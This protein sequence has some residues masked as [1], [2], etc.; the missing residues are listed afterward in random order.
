MDGQVKSGWLLGGAQ[1]YPIKGFVP[2]FVD[3]DKYAGT[4]SKQRLYVRKHFE[5]YRH[6]TSGDGQ[7]WPTTGFTPEEIKTGLTL[8]VGC[9]YG[10]FVDVVSRNGGEIVGLDLSTHSIELAQDF[11]GM[12]PDVHLVQA[13]L[14]RPPF[15][16]G[17][18]DRLYSIG[19]LHHT[20]STR[21]AVLACL[22]LVKP[23]GALAFWVYHPD[24]KA[25]T[26]KVRPITAR[27]PDRLLYSLCLGYQGLW[28]V[29]L[30]DFTPATYWKNVLGHYDSLS[31]VHAYSHTHDELVQWLEQAGLEQVI[32]L[33]RK[34]AVRGVKPLA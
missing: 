2:R 11:V 20:P 6:D 1:R 34:T 8:E 31:P 5:H 15:R 7:F 29:R 3:S 9:G 12:R 21:A 10:R 19:V 30:W 27:L 22:P 14:Y 18:F 28:S 13:D 24:D 25:R 23:G 17:A 26:D 33:P 32:A 4:F 16:Q